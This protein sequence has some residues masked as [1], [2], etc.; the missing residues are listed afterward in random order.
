MAEL[1]FHSNACKCCGEDPTDCGCTFPVMKTKKKL[2]KFRLPKGI[3]EIKIV[4]VKSGVYTNMAI[5]DDKIIDPKRV[6]QFLRKNG[7]RIMEKRL[8]YKITEYKDWKKNL[9]RI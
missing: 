6:K 7:K 5:F 9:V 2:M 3:S 8:G 1:S 4:R